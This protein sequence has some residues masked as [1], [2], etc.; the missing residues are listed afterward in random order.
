MITHTLYYKSKLSEYMQLNF[1][2]IIHTIFLLFLVLGI[3][4]NGGSIF[5]V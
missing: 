3:Y 2:S 1:K 5:L 4:I